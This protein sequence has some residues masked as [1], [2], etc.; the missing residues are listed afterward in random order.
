L[1]GTWSQSA[2]KNGITRKGY[3]FGVSYVNDVAKDRLWESFSSH[4]TLP[5]FDDEKLTKKIRLKG[6]QWDLKKMVAQ[7]NNHKKRLYNVYLKAGR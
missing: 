6:K 7:F 1:S 4:F 5:V 3:E 2:F